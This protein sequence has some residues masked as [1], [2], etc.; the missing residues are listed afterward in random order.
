MMNVV[1]D[2]IAMIEQ[3]HLVHVTTVALLAF[4]VRVNDTS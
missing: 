4:Y 3:C 2:I 1:A